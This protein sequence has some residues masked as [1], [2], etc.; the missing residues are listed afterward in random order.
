MAQKGGLDE[1]GE[2]YPCAVPSIHCL[3]LGLKIKNRDLPSYAP[4]WA[5]SNG[6]IRSAIEQIYAMSPTTVLPPG[7]P[8]F[9]LFYYKRISFVSKE[10]PSERFHV[11]KTDSIVS[12]QGGLYGQI[13]NFFYAKIFDICDFFCLIHPLIFHQMDHNLGVSVWKLIG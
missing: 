9:R 11:F 6:W 8:P 5:E 7:I 1:N 2:E 10:E 4:A 3:R 12:F 13:I